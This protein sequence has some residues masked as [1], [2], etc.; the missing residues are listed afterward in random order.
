MGTL[1]CSVANL[2]IGVRLLWLAKK[3]R[4]LPEF[5]LGTSF[6]LAGVIGWT[7]ILISR[8]VSASDPAAAEFLLGMGT[9][10]TNIGNAALLVFI[11]RVYRPHAIWV[12]ILI[13]ILISMMATST[14]YNSIIVGKT[15]AGP[16][17]PIQWL[18]M[19]ARLATYFWGALESFVFWRKLKKRA[20]IGL[21]EPVITNRVFLWGVAAAATFITTIIMTGT[22]IR[23]A[24][25][26]SDVEMFLFS[27][28]G[29]VAAFSTWLAFWPPARY[30][31]WIESSPSKTEVENG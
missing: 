20:L 7:A 15:Y 17:E 28:L 21:A 26:Y 5:T 6:I 2:I 9:L 12:V 29:F 23:R 22:Y 8:K 24:A 13:V 30:L 10:V 4:K 3:T 11:W 25:A 27:V 19:S 18:G 31:K 16:S 1:V 14:I